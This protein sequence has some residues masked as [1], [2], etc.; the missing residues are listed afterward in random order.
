MLPGTQGTFFDSPSFE[1]GFKAACA[2]SRH[3]AEEIDN[4]PS[5]HYQVT[6]SYLKMILHPGSPWE[7]MKEL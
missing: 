1:I 6:L 5:I 7:G 4:Q 2:I 3:Q